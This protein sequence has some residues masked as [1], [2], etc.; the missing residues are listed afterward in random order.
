[1]DYPNPTVT[2][3]S[4]L[5]NRKTTN[6]VKN[7]LHYINGIYIMSKKL[8]LVEIQARYDPSGKYRIEPLT[9]QSGN[10]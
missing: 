8:F 9:N 6:L 2:Q 1:M 4:D 5:H 3:Q 10:Q 7:L